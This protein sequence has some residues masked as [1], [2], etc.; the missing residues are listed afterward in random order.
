MLHI[1]K[2]YEPYNSIFN[3]FPYMDVREDMLRS[4]K[5]S[6]QAYQ[7]QM[8]STYSYNQ[9]AETN[10]ADNQAAPQ[11]FKYNALPIK[12]KDIKGNGFPPKGKSSLKKDPTCDLEKLLEEY[13]TRFSFY[14][15]EKKK[16]DQDSESV[17][18][19]AAKEASSLTP[20]EV[21]ALLT[22]HE[23]LKF[24]EK[25]IL[26]GI[27]ILDSKY[28]GI[29]VA[30]EEK[31]QQQSGDSNSKE[32]LSSRIGGLKASL[33]GFKENFSS[34]QKSIVSLYEKIEKLQ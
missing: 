21:E 27:E 18:S 26:E 30:F 17:K 28:Q 2:D 33:E 14:S 16:W 24:R 5:Y 6:L 31:Q 29:L 25:E 34:S 3:A 8:M 20:Q 19:Q 9:S 11:Y 15:G 23:N 7:Q 1:Y 13:E 10:Q 4:Y 22:K 12:P 32:K